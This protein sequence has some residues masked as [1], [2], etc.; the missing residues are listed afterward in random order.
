MENGSHVNGA[1]HRKERILILGAAG[2]DYHLFNTKYRDEPSVEVVGFTH[3]QIPHIESSRYPAALAGPLYPEGL[4]IWPQSQLEAV[5]MFK[6]TKTCL[7]ASPVLYALSPQHPHTLRL[8]WL[9]T[10]LDVHPLP[11]ADPSHREQ[12]L[13]SCTGRP[14]V[15]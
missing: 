7:A 15:P 14:T 4:P 5:I 2:R 8:M 3:A 12:P 1:A 9:Y 13:P 6:Q 10:L 11:C